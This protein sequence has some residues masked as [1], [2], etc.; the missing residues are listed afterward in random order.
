MVMG[1]LHCLRSLNWLS[2]FV[3]GGLCMVVAAG[4]QAQ[5]KDPGFGPSVRKTGDYPQALSI[6]KPSL[7]WRCGTGEARFVLSA[8]VVLD[9]VL[10]CTCEFGTVAAFETESGAE[11]WQVR[12]GPNGEHPCFAPFVDKDGVYCA[13]ENGG[14]T[15]LDRATGATLWKQP[16]GLGA[17]APLKSG[18]TV[19][20]AGYDGNLYA[21]DAESGDERWTCSLLDG[22]PADPPAFPGR[23]ARLDGTFVRPQRVEGTL[24]RPGGSASDGKILFQSIFDQSRVA[25][26]DCKTGKI[27]W[28][29]QAEGGIFA[30]PTV[31]ADHVFVGSHDRHLYC[32]DKETG[33]MIWKFATQGPIEAGAAI[34][35]DSVCAASCD[36]SL[37]CLDAKT[38]KPLWIFRTN[39]AR[40]SA[41]AI[42]SAPRIIGDS[43]CFAS[44]EGWLYSVNFATGQLLW[45]I[46]DDKSSDMCGAPATDGR[47]LFV[48]TRING[49]MNGFEGITAFD[50]AR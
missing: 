7:G 47:R 15:A 1:L 13:S 50:E 16:L 43:V 6:R 48:Q 5:D 11:L 35:N 38:G 9:G 4:A 29:F 25:A 3:A 28:S 8:P 46:D 31:T 20:T 24:A 26:V 42:Y 34:R 2:F 21:L 39:P 33:R 40:R 12:L 32:L 22:K 44:R 23:P 17:T 14:V 49:T 19:F 37:Y 36:G 18:N 27:V 45:K 10:Y 41:T 30:E